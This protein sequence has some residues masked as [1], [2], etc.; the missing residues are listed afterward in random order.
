MDAARNWRGK[1]LD[2][3]RPDALRDHFQK[4]VDALDRILRKF[5]LMKQ[6]RQ[7]EE[8]AEGASHDERARILA[9]MKA[10]QQEIRQIDQIDRC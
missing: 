3:T 10:C 1:M 6:I 2:K 5:Q 8:Q 7:L 4:S 9:D